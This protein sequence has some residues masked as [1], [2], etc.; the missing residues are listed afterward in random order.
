MRFGVVWKWFSMRN[1]FDQ[2][3]QPENRLTLA[4]MCSLH[5]D[6]KMLKKFVHWA[7]GEAAPAGTLSVVEQSLPGEDEGDELTDL[8]R[9]GLPDGWVY[10]DSGWA[11]LIESKIE[12]RLESD[13]IRRHLYTARRRGFTQLHMLA[14]VTDLPKG[15]LNV[16]LH[17]RRWTELY[18]WLKSELR[19]SVWANKLSEYMEILEVKLVAEEYLKTGTLTVF[20]GVPF[21]TE[22]PYNYLEAKRVLRLAMEELRLREDLDRAFGIDR[23][24]A[25]RAAITGKDSGS[26]WDYLRLLK[27]SEAKTFTEFPHLTLGVHR[28]FMHAIVTIP[29]GIRSDFR[30]KLLGNGFDAF[31]GVFSEVLEKFRESLGT[32]AGAVP[33]VELVQ[34]RYP[35][36][37]SEPFVDALLEF[38]LRTA[39]PTRNSVE[40]VPKPQPQW[41][42]SVYDALNDRNANLQLAV[43]VRFPYDRCMATSKPEILDHIACAWIACL[44]LIDTILD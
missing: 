28:E 27:A 24:V 22:S 41:L 38:D 20:T 42:K 44:P 30:R 43:G 11:L 23:N 25:G 13:Q 15:P 31:I 39:F 5:E 6:P 35:S 40:K 16:E 33:W 9:R 7:I 3:Q 32:V 12:C 14:L 19:D 34:R 1:L 17:T 18:T 36:Q 4:L 2:F 8:Q 10:S 26:V 37:R 21:G 29:N